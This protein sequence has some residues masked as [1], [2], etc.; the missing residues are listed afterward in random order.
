MHDIQKKKKTKSVTSDLVEGS[1]SNMEICLNIYMWVVWLVKCLSSI[2][3]TN[4]K[5][6]S[7]IIQ[8]SW[9]QTH[10]FK[11]LDYM[12]FIYSIILTTQ[13]ESFQVRISPTSGFTKFES[14]VQLGKCLTV[15]NTI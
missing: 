15:Y 9:T 13:L 6:E 4:Y 5:S 11:F 3:D 12:V 1:H 7:L 14:M 2:R 10:Q 8:F